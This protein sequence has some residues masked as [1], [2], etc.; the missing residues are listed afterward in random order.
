MLLLLFL[1]PFVIAFVMKPIVPGKM[2]FNNRMS[3]LEYTITAMDEY[4]LPTLLHTLWDPNVHTK[5]T[6]ISTYEVQNS[7]KTF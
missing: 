4:K 5:S 1:L 6:E 3:L 7:S 2:Q